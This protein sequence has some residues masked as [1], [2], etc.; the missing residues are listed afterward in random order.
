MTS[1]LSFGPLKDAS[2]AHGPFSICLDPGALQ[3]TFVVPSALFRQS[4]SN[5]GLRPMPCFS[6]ATTAGSVY[7][8]HMSQ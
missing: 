5:T 7:F 3:G 8:C 4:G 2:K 6:C 1:F